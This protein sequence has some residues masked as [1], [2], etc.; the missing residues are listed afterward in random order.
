MKRGFYLSV[1][2]VALLGVLAVADGGAQPPSLVLADGGIGFPDGS[3][4]TTAARALLIGPVL[5]PVTGQTTC[6]DAA[7]AVIDCATG[8]GPGQDGDLRSGV[9]WP[10][11]RFTK[12]GDGTVTD[13]LTGLI[14]LEDADC[15]GVT[16]VWDA[17][18]D[19][20]NTLFDGST[21]HAGGDCG[22]SDDSLP[23]MW[24]LPNVRELHSLV[25]FGV[26]EPAV[27][28]TAGTGKWVEGDPFSNVRTA[29]WSS[30]ALARYPDF[31]WEVTIFLGGI[32]TNGKENDRWAWPVR[33]GP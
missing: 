22:L 18:L 11:P 29:Y 28:N 1:S 9:R 26:W 30:T 2:G 15:A 17:A 10:S 23:G 32:G 4:Q 13:I 12:N 25:H 20:A 33:G 16:M 3:V 5:L 6:Y 27:A 7:G 31:A 24:R 8:I 21:D 19:F 14:W